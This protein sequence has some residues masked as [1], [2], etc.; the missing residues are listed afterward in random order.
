M[1]WLGNSSMARCYLCTHIQWF[2]LFRHAYLFRVFSFGQS[3]PAR[4]PP[5]LL[6]LP[7]AIPA[8]SPQR[9]PPGRPRR[10][11]GSVPGAGRR[12][13]TPPPPRPT[14]SQSPLGVPGHPRAA[15]RPPLGGRGSPLRPPSA[16]TASAPTLGRPATGRA[17]TGEGGRPPGTTVA[18][19]R[20]K[21]RL[22]SERS[23]LRTVF[24]TGQWLLCASLML[25][26]NA[27]SIDK[28]MNL[29]S[30]ARR[31]YSNKV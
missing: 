28:L 25:T 31:Y 12:P 20:I 4:A 17:P 11:C 27:N 5:H 2:D 15:G 6:T 29:A 14:Q 19:A 16:G 30:M 9:P 23:K 1:P 22:C 18:P 21:Y 24:T 3:L 7:P 8:H 10:G 13:R 26:H